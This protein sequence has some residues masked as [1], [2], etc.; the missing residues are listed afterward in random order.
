MFSSA[1]ALRQR[2]PIQSIVGEAM[3][4]DSAM[5]AQI[6]QPLTDRYPAAS[7]T[8]VVSV[9]RWRWIPARAAFVEAWAGRWYTPFISQFDPDE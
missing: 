8:I 9:N 5:V 6:A 7:P 3:L 1:F 4:I 2:L